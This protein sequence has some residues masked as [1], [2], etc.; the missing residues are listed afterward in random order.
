[1]CNPAVGRLDTI[2]IA[3]SA[4]LNSASATS[5][6]R[7]DRDVG[8]NCATPGSGSGTVPGAGGTVRLSFTLTGLPAIGLVHAWS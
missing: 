1:M 8:T 7:V 4:G 5:W 6:L 2:T 3:L